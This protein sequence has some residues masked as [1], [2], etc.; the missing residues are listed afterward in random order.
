MP[1]LNRMT[2]HHLYV[3]AKINV[4]PVCMLFENWSYFALDDI[5]CPTK[6]NLSITYKQK[7]PHFLTWLA[8]FTRSVIFFSLL[9]FSLLSMIK[10]NEMKIVQRERERMCNNS[11]NHHSNTHMNKV[12]RHIMK[13]RKSRIIIMIILLTSSHSWDM[14]R[15]EG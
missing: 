3:C 15:P 2:E 13:V 5:V 7:I 10:Y 12:K 9:S 4:Y 8:F 11:P 1:L 14:K 6:L